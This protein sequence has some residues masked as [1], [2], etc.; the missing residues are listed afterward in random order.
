MA[1]TPTFH[2]NRD[3]E[4]PFIV[5]FNSEGIDFVSGFYVGDREMVTPKAFLSHAPY[6]LKREVMAEFIKRS[7]KGK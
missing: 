2:N 3:S 1:Y 4:D 7:F 6:E 5:C